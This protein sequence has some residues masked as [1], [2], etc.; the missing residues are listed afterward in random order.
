[1]VQVISSTQ[2]FEE[3]LKFDG[4]IVV[5]FFAEW[6]GPCKAIAPVLDQL[7]NRYNSVKFIKVDVD[8]L[9]D[10]ARK[11]EVNAMPTFKFIKN[12][13]VVDEVVGADPNKIVRVIDTHK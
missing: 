9:T 1:M 3:A 6:C 10:L 7:S 2:E 4:L 12:G 11:Y 13:K 5:D 8:Q